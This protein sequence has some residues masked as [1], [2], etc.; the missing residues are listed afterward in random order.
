MLHLAL[1]AHNR[2]EKV[3]VLHLCV[4]VCVAAKGS[5]FLDSCD[6]ERENICGMIQGEGD[7]ADWI[8]VGT[9][10]GGPDSDYSNMGKCTGEYTRRVHVTRHTT[11]NVSENPLGS[12]TYL[13]GIESIKRAEESLQCHFYVIFLI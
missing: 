9:A 10:P 1:F 13:S 3:K 6:F 7:Q 8:R 12:F 2:V 4:D 5:T 11:W